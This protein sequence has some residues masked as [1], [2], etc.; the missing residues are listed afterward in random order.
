MVQAAQVGVSRPFLLLCCS[1]YIEELCVWFSNDI[2]VFP[3]D[4]MSV[5]QTG[6]VSEM[7]G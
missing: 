1:S 6:R 4:M 2:E 3:L 7:E 5:S